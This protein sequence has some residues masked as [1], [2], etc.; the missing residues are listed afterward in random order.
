MMTTLGQ[1]IEQ[2]PTWSLSYFYYGDSS[3]LSKQERILADS[4]FTSLCDEVKALG[5]SGIML[6]YSEEHPH[7]SNHPAFG[8]PCE[9]LPIPVYF[10]GKTL[11][12][13]SI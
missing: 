3:G 10:L 7:F 5:G 13:K 6:G 8:L 1:Y 11:E 12:K 2:I 9:V 4:W